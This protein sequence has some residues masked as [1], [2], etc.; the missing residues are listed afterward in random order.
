MHD[1]G[2]YKTG[3]QLEQE[4]EEA[5][6]NKSTFG[7]TDPNKYAVSDEDDSDEELPFACL[8]CRKEFK[9]PV[10]TKCGH[11]FCEKCAIDHQRTSPK[12]YA[13]GASTG[14][15]FTTAKNMLKRLRDKKQRIAE[16]RGETVDGE[17]TKDNEFSIEG[18]EERPADSSEDDSDSD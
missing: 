15:V 12:C 17:E 2:D 3:W 18:L 1:R 10:V 5:Q 11:Y 6:R 13:C 4:W 14:G 9:D 7:S 8:L 16:E